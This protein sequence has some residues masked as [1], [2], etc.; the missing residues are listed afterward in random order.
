MKLANQEDRVNT[1]EKALDFVTEQNTIFAKEII[2]ERAYDKQAFIRMAVFDQI[3][4][5]GTNELKQA[6]QMKDLN[7]I[8]LTFSKVSEEELTLSALKIIQMLAKML[9]NKTA[10]SKDQLK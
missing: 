2:K 1:I 4:E 3:L 7:L 10:G 9:E 8:S 6:S 5:L